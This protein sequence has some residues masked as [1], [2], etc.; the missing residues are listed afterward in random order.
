MRRA[1]ERPARYV[2]LTGNSRPADPHYY[3][4]ILSEFE[5]IRMTN[6]VRL[7]WTS[8]SDNSNDGSAAMYMVRWSRTPITDELEWEKATRFRGAPAPTQAP[9]S[10]IESLIR[11]FVLSDKA[12]FL[13]DWRVQLLHQPRAGVLTLTY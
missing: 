13:I 6:I 1:A 11:A 10:N 4:L 7:E 9:V 3:Y 12:P 5:V 8:P 2:F